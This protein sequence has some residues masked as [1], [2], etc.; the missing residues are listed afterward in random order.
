[1]TLSLES[2]SLFWV[3]T[4]DNELKIK[5]KITEEIKIRLEET[6]ARM[7]LPQAMHVGSGDELFPFGL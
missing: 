1:M 7:S 5:I 2:K 3:K 4:P 6:L